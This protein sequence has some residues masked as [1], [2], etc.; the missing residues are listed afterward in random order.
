MVDLLQSWD[1]NQF[2]VWCLLAQVVIKPLAIHHGLRWY[3]RW[4]G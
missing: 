1:W 4:Y 2:V 3:R